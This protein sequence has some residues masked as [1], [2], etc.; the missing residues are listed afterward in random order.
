M[1]EGVGG[2]GHASRIVS[3][4]VVTSFDGTSGF[5]V[6]GGDGAALSEALGGAVDSCALGVVEAIVTTGS[7]GDEGVGWQAERVKAATPSRPTAA[8]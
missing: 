8:R 7:G 4:V 5:E 2:V 3:P 6:G 1:D